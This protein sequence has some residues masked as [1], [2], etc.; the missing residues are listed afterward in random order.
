MQEAKS[1]DAFR[2][3][4]G[5]G[6]EILYHSRKNGWLRQTNWRI[7]EWLETGEDR[8]KTILERSYEKARKN[9][10]IHLDI[11]G[12]F[13][14]LKDVKTGKLVDTVV[15]RVENPSELTGYNKRTG[16]YTNWAKTPKD[17][18]IYKLCVKGDNIVQG[19]IGIKP[20]EDHQAVYLH[21]ATA[22]PH[23]NPQLL[24]GAPKK[25]EGVGGHL[26]AI[27]AEKSIEY[28]YG[29]AMYGFAANKDLVRLYT[30]KYGARYFPVEH[31]NEV[32]YDEAAAMAILKEYNYEWEK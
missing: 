7:N 3:H 9:G 24:D 13:P 12:L 10:I 21:W 28:G 25:Y 8:I 26:M 20:V 4:P 16:W 19:L 31:I 15:S 6:C 30:E 22:A 14:C 2:R 11:D 27:A 18:E 23:N 29:G 17:V 32:Y 1:K 5:C